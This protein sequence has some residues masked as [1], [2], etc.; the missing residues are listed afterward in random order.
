[1]GDA[2]LEARLLNAVEEGD[3]DAVRAVFDDVAAA[4][5]PEREPPQQQQQVPPQQPPPP[6]PSDTPLR[7][8]SESPLAP[9]TPTVTDPTT[10]IELPELNATAPRA[11]LDTP[12]AR[13]RRLLRRAATQ[14]HYSVLH[15]AVCDGNREMAELLI[16]HQA[17]VNATTLA[18]DSVLHLASRSGHVALVEL[19]IER[20]ADTTIRTVHER[21]Q[22]LGGTL[23]RD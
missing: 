18:N 2:A 23:S 4:V 6:E 21:R 15:L 11:S 8:T 10:P 16:D 12:A 9:A 17:D 13:V 14:D 7:S 19:L 20:R 1:M 5:V 22:R 3:L